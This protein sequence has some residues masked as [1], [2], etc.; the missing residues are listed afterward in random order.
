MTISTSSTDLPQITALEAGLA[1]AREASSTLALLDDAQ[2]AAVLNA[3]A[4]QTL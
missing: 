1:A 4:D 3:L 2:T